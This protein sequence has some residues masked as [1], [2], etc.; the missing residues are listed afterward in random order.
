M[1]NKIRIVGAGLIGTSV[2]LRLKTAGSAIEIIDT[3]PNAMKLAAD[4]VKSE[5]IADP[6]LIIITV[7][8]SANVKVVIDQL[9]SNPKSI[10][11]DFASVK[12]DLLLKVRELSANPENFLMALKMLEQICL[13]AEHG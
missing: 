8:V 5:V 2:G 11:C 13:M 6:D 4:L 7:P 1:I 3:N 9:K 12:S 10:V